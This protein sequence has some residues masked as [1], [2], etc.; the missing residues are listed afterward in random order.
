M[1]YTYVM[2]VMKMGNIMPRAGIEPIVS[3]AGVLIITPLK[4]NKCIHQLIKQ[5]KFQS[6]AIGLPHSTAPCPILI[7]QSA[8]LVSYKYQLLRHWFDSTRVRSHEVQIPSPTKTGDG[9]TTP[10]ENPFMHIRSVCV[11]CGMYIC[12]FQHFQC[13]KRIC[14]GSVEEP[15]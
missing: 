9:H 15:G 2:E 3:L 10:G 6:Q 5:G 4:L 12:N 8:R 11:T 14:G 13:A 7:M 1:L